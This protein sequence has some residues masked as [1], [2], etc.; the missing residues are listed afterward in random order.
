MAKVRIIRSGEI[1]DR[2]FVD[3]MDPILHAMLEDLL[4]DLDVMSGKMD[5]VDRPRPRA[6]RA[7]IKFHILRLFEEDSLIVFRDPSRA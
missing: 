7:F 6:T 2:L 1:R 4:Q 3:L 5:L